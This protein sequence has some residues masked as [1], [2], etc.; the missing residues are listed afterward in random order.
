[1]Q[2]ELYPKRREEPKR[3]TLGDVERFDFTY[4][5]RDVPDAETLMV[6]PRTGDFF[7]VTKPH[8]S[9]PIMFRARA[10]L[11]AKRPQMLEEVATLPV[12]GDATRQDLPVD[13]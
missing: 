10:P 4:P 7:L 6:D 2:V 5:T 3:R 1:M 12:L 13:K 9:I 11:D 8:D